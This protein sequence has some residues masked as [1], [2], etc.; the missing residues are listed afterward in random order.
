MPTIEQLDNMA[1]LLGFRDFG[2]IIAASDAKVKVME[3]TIAAI[4]AKGLADIAYWQAFNN[5]QH[6]PISG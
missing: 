1:K 6:K 4:Q 2:D 3:L 5:G